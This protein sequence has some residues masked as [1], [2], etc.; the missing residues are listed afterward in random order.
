M[1]KHITAFAALLFLAGC[2]KPSPQ[3]ILSNPKAAPFVGLS[4]AAMPD[5]DRKIIMEASDDFL[6]VLAGKKPIHAKFDEE[7]PLP[8]DGGTTFYIGEGYKLTVVR[9]ISSFGEFNGYAYGPAL[10][11]NEDFAPGNESTIS[12][13]RVYSDAELGKLLGESSGL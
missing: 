7:A 3:V 4:S 9:S 8:T 12:D 13:I 2:S 1:E 5:A 10:T 6:A 11:F